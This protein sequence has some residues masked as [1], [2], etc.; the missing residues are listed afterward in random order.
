MANYAEEKR[1]VESCWLD[2]VLLKTDNEARCLWRML[3]VL[4]QRKTVPSFKKFS[5]K[6]VT[7]HFYLGC[8]NLIPVAL[9]LEILGDEIKWIICWLTARKNSF[10]SFHF[11]KGHFWVAAGK[12]HFI[13]HWHLAGT[14][15][16]A[17]SSRPFVSC[18]FNILGFNQLQ[19][20][21]IG[22]GIASVV[23]LCKH[24]PLSLT[25]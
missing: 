10:K 6:T 20:E 8:S 24:F 21:S 19:S 13:W 11:N 16:E 23:D 25:K 14:T 22:G 12:C 5:L 15:S 18:R 3:K 17:F 4:L 9:N 2:L 7:V 1:A